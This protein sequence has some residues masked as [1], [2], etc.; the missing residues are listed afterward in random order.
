MIEK[1][2]AVFA[3]VDWRESTGARLYR[4]AKERIP[5]GVQLLSK[6]PERYLPELWPAY[7][8][9]ARGCE[10][11]DL[12]GRRFIDMCYSGIGACLLG[13]ADPDVNAAVKRAVED[14]SLCTL[15]TPAEVDLA[16]LLC[17]L[18]PWADMVRY[19]RSGGEAMAVAVRIARAATGR[20]RIAVC[21][22]HGWSDWYIAANLSHDGALDG[23]LMPGLPPSGVP[24]GLQGT[25]STFRYNRLDELEAIVAEGPAPAAIVLEP[26]RFDRPDDGFLAGVRAIA[27]RV[28]AVLVFDEITAGWRHVVGGSH[29]ML[30]VEPDVAV[31][32]KSISNG[33]PMGAV[34]GRGGV[35]ESAQNS[36]ISST[37][38][39][40]AIGPTAALATV[41]KMRSVRLPDHTDAVGRRAQEGW[42]LLATRHGLD[43]TVRG[44]PALT[45]FSLNYPGE[46]QALT[47]LLT[48]L[49]LERGYLATT[50]YYP[51]YAQDQAIVDGYLTALDDVFAVLREAVEQDDVDARLHGPV[52]V[53]GF[54]R[55]T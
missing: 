30:G 12:D 16:D 50:T 27:R 3:G 55:L 10:V 22:Y 15:N 2:E 32:A 46:S 52:A 1:K 47:T 23:H 26:V 4:R 38:W 6:Q 11:W 17:E 25:V 40:E 20:D 29:L 42:R 51:T 33:F 53:S 49:M 9:R 5:G 36:F 19:T 34:I 37:Y 48:Q 7:Y 44:L 35:M 21:G 24:R 45:T 13:F 54:A 18:H 43:L 39:T 31:F 8:S 14:G 41:R 28:G